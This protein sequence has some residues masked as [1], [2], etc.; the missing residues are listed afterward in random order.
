MCETWSAT[1]G[2]N[3]CLVLDESEL[4]SGLTPLPSTTTFIEEEARVVGWREGDDA[5]DEPGMITKLGGV[6]SWIQ[7]E[8]EGPAKP[9]RWVAQ[10]DC[11]H[12]LD[13][14]SRCDA[15]NYGDAG[16]AY[17]YV[18]AAEGKPVAL[19]FWQCC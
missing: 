17:V 8:N 3:A 7:G 9:W 19:M 4:A 10:F 2:A 13:D 14:G 6:P 12:R 16:M 1:S 15:A 18:N 5:G 11:Q